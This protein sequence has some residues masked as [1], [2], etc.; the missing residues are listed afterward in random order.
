MLCGV[1]MGR[2]NQAMSTLQA[3]PRTALSEMWVVIAN[4]ANI[5]HGSKHTLASSKLQCAFVTLQSW[6]L[7]CPQTHLTT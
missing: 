3:V 5:V 6:P 4:A 7:S 1:D 2:H